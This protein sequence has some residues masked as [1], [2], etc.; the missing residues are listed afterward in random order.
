M[1]KE[2]EE[3]MSKDNWIGSSE[4]STYH[5]TRHACRILTCGISDILRNVS[6]W[7]IPLLPTPLAA[8]GIPSHGLSVFS[9]MHANFLTDIADRL[10]PGKFSSPLRQSTG[11]S[12]GITGSTLSPP[13]PM[14]KEQ[15]GTQ[16][17]VSAINDVFN[18]VRARVSESMIYESLLKHTFTWTQSYMDAVLP[19]LNLI[20]R[21]LTWI[22]SQQDAILP[23][24]PDT[25]CGTTWIKSLSDVALHGSTVTHMQSTWINSYLIALMPALTLTRMQYY[26]D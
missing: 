22:D 21:S 2:K 18:I 16:A 15:L 12:G 7:I 14:G 17:K 6:G 5:M 13:G 23:G 3:L 20:G 24:F 8:P 19:R 4:D 9:T 25:R 11:G 10:M 1:C 26:L